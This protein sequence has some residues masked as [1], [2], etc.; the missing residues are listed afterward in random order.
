MLGGSILDMAWCLEALVSNK[1]LDRRLAF[2]ISGDGEVTVSF[3]NMTCLEVGGP[4]QVPSP[5]E[6]DV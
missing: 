4:V 6:P 5:S 1:R 2:G 3:W